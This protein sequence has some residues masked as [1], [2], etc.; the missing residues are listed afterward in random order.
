MPDHRKIPKI[1][2]S[3]SNA[4]L[5]YSNKGKRADPDALSML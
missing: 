1:I 2:I 5:G 4:A 3:D